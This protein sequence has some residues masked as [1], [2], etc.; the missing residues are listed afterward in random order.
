VNRR[1]TLV[2][3]ALAS[4]LLTSACGQGAVEDNA[5]RSTAGA[6]ATP[7][8]KKSSAAPVDSSPRTVEAKRHDAAGGVAELAE[9]RVTEHKGF[10]RVRF[11]FSRG[12]S[13]V[14][15]EYMDELREPGRGRKVALAGEH[16]LVL[17]FV[18]VERQEPA[19]SAAQ[20]STVREVRASGVFEGEMIVGIGTRSKGEGPA[21]YRVGLEG[22]TVTVDVAH[23]GSSAKG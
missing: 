18:G 3:F 22:K 6:D 23:R 13:K 17:V 21:G 7:S 2:A 10:D 9:V 14:F 11:Q 1:R 4:T 5:G 19:I 15:A 16:K 8:A 12:V 20:T